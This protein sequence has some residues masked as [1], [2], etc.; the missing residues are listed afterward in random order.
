[1]EKYKNIKNLTVFVILI[2]LVIGTVIISGC[3]KPK[4]I[5][6]GEIN[7]SEVKKEAEKEIKEE[8]KKLSEEKQLTAKE[9]FTI[10][11]AKAKGWSSN[12]KLVRIISGPDIKED[13]T[14]GYWTF[15]FRIPG[16][17]ESLFNVD[18]RGEAIENT[19]AKKF[20]Y[21]DKVPLPEGWLDSKEAYQKSYDEFKKLRPSD[22]QDYK[23]SLL[24]LQCA[25]S[26]PMS[27]NDFP[28]PCWI[29]ILY[30]GNEVAHGA[31]VDAVTGEFVTE[32][33]ITK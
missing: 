31:A 21:Y 22:F 2:I 28:K 17:E 3:G 15:K 25:T 33:G 19:E 27:G 20:K 18:I 12:A 32:W 10:A 8:I 30:K 29:L 5:K 14:S 7:I 4:E 24:G 26:P 9:A 23:V 1:M 13:G 11:E 16:D 6:T